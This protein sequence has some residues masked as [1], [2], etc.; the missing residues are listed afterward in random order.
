MEE[1]RPGEYMPVYEDD[2][3]TMAILNQ[4]DIDKNER[5]FSDALI[6]RC[7]EKTE[8]ELRDMLNVA[9]NLLE[10]DAKSQ[11]DIDNMNVERC[12]ELLSSQAELT[13]HISGVEQV[14]QFIQESDL[15]SGSGIFAEFDST[16]FVLLRYNHTGSN[17]WQNQLFY[18]GTVPAQYQ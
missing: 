5:N 15:L 4:M 18:K 2:V 9:Y 1:K 6:F 13:G 14:N 8:A 12:M 16:H 11:K 10:E 17:D 3:N 7:E